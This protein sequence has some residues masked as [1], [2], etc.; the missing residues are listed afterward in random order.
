[1]T[2]EE[3]QELVDKGRADGAQLFAVA[4]A[5]YKT[6]LVVISI[7]G[8]AG[9][10]SI[11]TTLWD[12]GIIPALLAFAATVAICA[13]AYALAVLGANGSK[14]LVHLLMSNLALLENQ[15]SSD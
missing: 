8:A 15:R 7:V 3:L 14:V 10:I 5:V 9:V 12:R 11:F 4:D 13:T 2:N 6:S 1:M